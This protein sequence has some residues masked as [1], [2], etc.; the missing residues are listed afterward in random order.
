[1]LPG[2]FLTFVQFLYVTCQTLSTQL[3]WNHGSTSASGWLPRVKK[4]VVPVRRWMIQVLLFLAV[5]ILNNYAFG[6]KVSRWQ[7]EGL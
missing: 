4:T 7:R 2:I 5:S 6:L 3:I 1:M